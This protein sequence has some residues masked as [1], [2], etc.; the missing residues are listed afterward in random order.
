MG[1]K[2]IL[3]TIIKHNVPEGFCFECRRPM[4]NSNK[5]KKY[6]STCVYDNNK[7][8]IKAKFKNHTY[9]YVYLGTGYSSGQGKRCGSMVLGAMSV[10]EDLWSPPVPVTIENVN[11]SLNAHKSKIN[12]CNGA[13][14][15]AKDALLLAKYFDNIRLLKNVN[16]NKNNT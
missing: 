3:T 6:H 8:G 4:D 2:K 11:R 5:T 14:V 10:A 15:S 1:I 7:Y 16:N 9:M 12:L 13:W